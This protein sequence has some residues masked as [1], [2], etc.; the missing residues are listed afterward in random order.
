[1]PASRATASTAR[2]CSSGQTRPPAMFVV[3][4]IETSRERGA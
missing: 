4:S 1:M 3:C 2:I